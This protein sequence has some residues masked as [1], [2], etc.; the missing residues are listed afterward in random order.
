MNKFKFLFFIILAGIFN[1]CRIK[2]TQNI[3]VSDLTCE[4]L[5]NPLGIDVDTPRFGWKISDLTNLRGQHQT[6]YHILVATTPDKLNNDNADIWDS[7][8]VASEQSN[9]VSYNGHKLQSG[10][11]YY[12]KVKVYDRN[13]Q[14]SAWS[15]IARFSMGLLNPDDWKG[16][17]IKHPTATP[18]K[19]IWFR[20]I[21]TLDTQA[22]SAFVYVAS[23]GYHELYVNGQKADERVL[24]PALTRIDKR[25]LY[26]TYD[27]ASLLKKGDN[28]IAL[29]Y[30]PG[31]SRNDSFAATTS[32]IRDSFSPWVDQTVLLQLNGKTVKNKDFTIHSDISWKCAESYSQNTGKFQ[33]ADMG[34]EEVDGKRYTS[35][36][37]TLDFDDSS[38]IAARK[39]NPLKQGGE[40]IL[41]AQMTDPSR[42]I[43]T[44]SARQILEIIPG[45]WQVDM[46]KSFTGF[47]EASFDGLQV[48]DTVLIQVSNRIAD[49]EEFKQR[50][51]YIARGE[52]GE[53]FRNRFNFFGGRYIS[54]TGLKHAPKSGDITG[55]AVSSAAPRTGYFECSDSMF[56]RIYEVD[57]WTYEMCNV[58][59]H[60]VD[61][62]T[63]ERLGYGSEGAFQT[64]WGLGLPCFATGAFYVKNIRDW[65]DVQWSDGRINYVAPQINDMWGGPISGAAILNIAEEHYL[66]YGDKKVLESACETGKKWLDFLN[67]YTSEGL[68]TPYDVATH[69]I[70]EWCSPYSHREKNGEEAALFF[71]NCVY[72]MTLDQF[73]RMSEILNRRDELTLYRKRLQVVRMKMHEK[74]YNPDIHSYLHGDQVRTTFALFTGIVPD[75]LQSAVLKHLEEDLTG[76]HPYFDV[77]SFGRYPYFK[78]LF[79]YSQLQEIISEILS[80][81]AY[82]GY[83]YFLSKGE[84]TWPETWEI[85]PD[86]KIHTSYTGISSWFI[87]CLAGITPSIE[88]PGYRTVNIRPNVVSNLT[89]A[90]AGLESPYGLIESGWHKEKSHIFY[91]MTIPVGAKA[92]IYLSAPKGKITENGQTLDK[93]AGIKIIEEKNDGILIQASAGKYQF[94]ETNN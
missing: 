75:S 67:P 2:E 4:Y 50:Q 81:R 86:S 5:V 69:F 37:N 71:N 78:V 28:V 74:Y 87:K 12:W 73:I 76:E 17:W 14:S 42:I 77:G 10:G 49:L 38:W 27:I 18:E 70:G 8:V 68:L 80:K 36:W 34:G 48:G 59:G 32:Q 43:D 31:W 7:G 26:V 15:Q 35:K 40:L 41:S 52:K 51:F 3:S 24:A 29:W 64:T 54:F 83:G 84:N 1:S 89:Y 61:C 63:R 60:T 47:L 92:R 62:P 22:A 88:E 33:F 58:E 9:P 85:D 6:A 93:V 23:V 56:N 19:H 72:A 82:P 20:K 44:I 39:T 90:K 79:A 57:R 16:D 53:T 65:S 91:N 30:G 21:L 66:S 55:Y 94:Q 45:T 46:G 13:N 11:N 25:V